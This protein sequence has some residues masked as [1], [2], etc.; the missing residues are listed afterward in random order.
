MTLALRNLP[1]YAQI[2]RLLVRYGRD[3][4]RMPPEIEAMLEAEG[5]SDPAEP[6]P[7]AEAFARDLEALGPTFVKLGQLLSTRADLLPL[8][9]LSALARLQDRVEPFG[10]AEV[11]RIVEEELGA[12]ISKAFGEFDPVPLAAAS[13]GQVHRATLRDGRRVAVKV[14]RPAIQ[15]VAASDLAA[16]RELAA[17]LDEHTELGRTYGL[18]ALVDEFGRTLARELDYRIE[19]ENLL[20]L[21]R[22]MAPYERILV[23]APVADYTRTRVLTMDLVHGRK[24]TE[25][26]PVTRLDFDGAAL[27][28]ELFRAYL[29]QILIAGFFHADP[30]PGNVFLTDDHR[31]ALIDLGMVGRISSSR[32]ERMLR[33]LLAAAEQRGDEAA[34][35]A[36]ELGEKTSRY[37]ERRFAE[38]TG[39]LAAELQYNKLGD[40]D[41]GRVLLGVV[42]DSARAGV[43]MPSE[44]ALLGKTLLQLDRIARALDPAFDPNAAIR[45]HAA[46]ITARRVRQLFS[47]GSLIGGLNDFK[48]LVRRMP[49]RVGRILDRL[50]AN[51]LEIRVQAIDQRLL[52]EGFQKVANRI[53]TGLVLAALIVGSAM[54]IQVP[55]T[56]R[57][58]GYPGFAILFFLA[59]ATGGVALLW[60]ILTADLPNRR[61]RR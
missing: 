19:A 28:D 8:P 35:A 34:A 41:V 55:T 50:A 39:R 22:L 60:N 49:D 17:W 48:E 1:R 61:K 37:D 45:R 14:Q 25:I 24:V 42:H 23:P 52:M 51:E 4:A 21:G 31:L 3:L 57:I 10:F 18:A 16:L 58:A 56:F 27:A 44:L 26:A 15:E 13:L 47:T 5:E 12:R 38:V 29:E 32:Q 54:L 33:I 11:E 20:E 40:L 2:A 43:R 36:A 9:Y 59:A 7:G 53:A 46:E 30:H 6:A